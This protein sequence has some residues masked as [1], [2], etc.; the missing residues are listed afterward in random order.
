MTWWLSIPLEVRLV[1]VGVFA[2]ALATQLNRGIYRLA[3]DVRN[4]GPWSPA[5]ATA[6]PRRIT[7]YL[8]IVGWL[9]LR[10]ESPIHGAGFWL[11]PLLLELTVAVGFAALYAYEVGGGLA[12][13]V[14]PPAPLSMLTIHLQY[15]AHVVLISL[16][17]VATFIDFDEQTIPDEITVTGTLLGLVLMSLLPAM[18]P[19]IPVRAMGGFTHEHLVFSSSQT[20]LAWLNGLGGP[21]SWP[22]FLD[23]WKGLAYGLAAYAAWCL[24]ILPKLWTLRR[25]WGKA[26]QYLFASIARHSA[27]WFVLGMA[28][29]GSAGI[30]AVWFWGGLHWQSLFTALVG[31]AFGGGLIWAVRIVGR[32]ALRREAM[33]FGDV[34]LMAM[35]GTFVGWQSSLIIFFLAPL[36]ALLISLTQWILTGRRDI[37][38][39]PYLSL[40]TLI[41]I[42][43]WPRFWPGYA[44]AVF[45]MGWLIPALV[46]VCLILMAGLLSCWRVAAELADRLTSDNRAN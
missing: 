36:A 22:S 15:A 29:L 6:P 21:N 4:I 46:G 13:R 34:T 12:P 41:L 44:A 37:A 31:M 19:V 25:G 33:G 5:A 38:F 20:S 17:L 39:G 14:V 16:L 40:G 24:A 28:V 18:Q 11:R 42:F 35:I 23:G 43:I 1:L 45:S 30:V 2:A 3:W 10:R 7:D 26:F 27:S 8:P 32:L 9:G